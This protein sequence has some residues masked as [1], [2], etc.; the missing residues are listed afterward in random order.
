MDTEQAKAVLLAFMAEMYAWEKAAT[1]SLRSIEYDKKLADDLS[2]IFARY[3]TP[4]KSKRCREISLGV[5]FPFEYKPETHPITEVQAEGKYLFFYI[6]EDRKGLISLLR[7]RMVY[8][9]D[10]WRIDKKEW[11]NNQKWKNYPF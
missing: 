5:R 8:Q 9:N 7:Y 3:C 10:Q 11:L 1:K 4:K 6:E 2:S